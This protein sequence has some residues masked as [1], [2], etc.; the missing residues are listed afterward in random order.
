MGRSIEQ[1]TKDRTGELYGPDRQIKVL[2]WDGSR[3]EPSST[4]KYGVKLYTAICTK[5]SLEDPELYGKPFLVRL[6]TLRKGEMNCG[7]TKFA[8]PNQDQYEV[9][10]KREC[11]KRHYSYEGFSGEWLNGATRIILICLEHGNKW[12][13]ELKNFLN[14]QGTC[15]RCVERD[16]GKNIRHPDNEVTKRLQESKN[17]NKDYTFWRNVGDNPDNWYY[18]CPVCSFDEYVENG[19][20]T[21]IFQGLGY[22]ILNGVKS[23]RCADAFR[24]TEKQFIHRITKLD[25]FVS[26]MYK[27]LGWNGEYKGSHSIARVHCLKHGEFKMTVSNLLNGH[28]CNGCA[29]SGFTSSKDAYLYVL[30]ITDENKI[31]GFCGFGITNNL[32]SRLYQHR[33][34]LRKSGYY[35]QEIASFKYSGDLAKKLETGIKNNFEITSQSISGFVK[36][37]TNINNF[38]KVIN[39]VENYV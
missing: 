28:R 7:C 18:E 5:C 34:V 30:K 2:G 11:L 24:W 23:C 15:K 26:G 31:R 29:K 13:S 22:N 32:T 37:A 21:G 33:S 25:E 20:C 17:Y 35:I 10:I 9:M 14:G 36:E 19:V 27:F 8:R 16:A 3:A 12:E 4:E 1:K 38:T 39:Y 6:Q